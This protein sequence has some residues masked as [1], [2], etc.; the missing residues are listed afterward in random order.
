MGEGISASLPKISVLLDVWKRRLGGTAAMTKGGRYD[1]PAAVAPGLRLLAILTIQGFRG[2]GEAN[3][4]SREDD[5]NS[6]RAQVASAEAVVVW[7]EGP[8]WKKK[9]RTG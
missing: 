7:K 1:V 2:M 4:P 9:P 6:L 3:C 5:W 8:C